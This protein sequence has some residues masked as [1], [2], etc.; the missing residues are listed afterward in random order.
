MAQSCW[1]ALRLELAP[2]NEFEGGSPFHAYLLHAPCK[3]GGVD[4][5][6]LESSRRTALVRRFLPG[7]ADCLGVLMA[8]GNEWRMLFE[9]PTAFEERIVGLSGRLLEPGALMVVTDR[10]GR[11]RPFRLVELT[12]LDSS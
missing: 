4:R 6:T 7:E 2:A 9:R 11:E 8:R 3:D 5:K 10:S 1:H 12:A